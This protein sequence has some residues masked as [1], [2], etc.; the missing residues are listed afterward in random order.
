LSESRGAVSGRATE[1][2]VVATHRADD[3]GTVAHRAGDM[4]AAHRERAAGIWRRPERA[5]H[6]WPG[7]CNG[8]SASGAG[9]TARQ[10]AT[11]ATPS[12]MVQLQTNA[13]SRVEALDDARLYS[14]RLRSSDGWDVGRTRRV[15]QPPGGKRR[16]KW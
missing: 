11:P 14:G 16:G 2:L 7:G 5:G 3:T 4:C 1:R 9:R 13:C 6:P 12:M 10:I 15:T 8:A